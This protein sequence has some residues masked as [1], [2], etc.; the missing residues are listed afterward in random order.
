MPKKPWKN[1]Y[2]RRKVQKQPRKDSFCIFTEGQTE[3]LYFNAFRLSSATIRCIGLGGGNAPHLAREAVG[4]KKMEQYRNF[5][6]YYLVFDRDDNNADEIRE[7]IQIAR[8]HQMKWVFSNPCFE[9][10][11]LLHYALHETETD[12]RSLKGRLLCRYIE[13][14]H[15]TMPGIY[16]RLM[17]L[18][19]NA[20]RNAQ[21]LLDNWQDWEN[22]L[23]QANPS[24]NALAL[25][26]HMNRFLK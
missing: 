2:N 26:K 6:T 12:A 22:R 10:W 1:N 24:T 8:Q 21:Q 14:Y 4:K 18:Q 19:P 20:F 15:E 7:A 17:E 3:A 9:L 16:G 25:V 13:Q 11:F 5:D 23:H